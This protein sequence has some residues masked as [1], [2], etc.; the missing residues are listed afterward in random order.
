MKIY[1]M[2][3]CHSNRTDIPR[4]RYYHSESPEKKLYENHSS[5]HH[6]PGSTHRYY[7]PRQSPTSNTYQPSSPYACQTST[8]HLST[9]TSKAKLAVHSKANRNKQSPAPPQPSKVSYIFFS[10]SILHFQFSIL[11]TFATIFR[12]TPSPIQGA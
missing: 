8:N 12:I 7:N 9:G 11:L 5:R 10:F 3:S 1:W 2:S 6:P 4:T